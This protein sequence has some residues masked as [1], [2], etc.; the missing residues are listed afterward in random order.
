MSVSAVAETEV[1]TYVES[2][3]EGVMLVVSLSCKSFRF[4]RTPPSASAASSDMTTICAAVQFKRKCN[5]EQTKWNVGM[6]QKRRVSQQTTNG[7]SC[8]PRST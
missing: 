3:R 4:S 1:A 6:E 7:N 5:A 2:V 8:M